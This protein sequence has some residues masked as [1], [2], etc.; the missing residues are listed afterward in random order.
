MLLKEMIDAYVNLQHEP[1]KGPRDGGHAIPFEGFIAAVADVKKRLPGTLS[2]T[3]VDTL[4]QQHKSWVAEVQA[5]LVRCKV[6]ASLHVCCS[7]LVSPLINSFCLALRTVVLV[8]PLHD[9]N[10]CLCECWLCCVVQD[11]GDMAGA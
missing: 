6:S 9:H 3:K 10:C 8:H 2:Q 11:Q 1:S 5:E 4:I 7:H